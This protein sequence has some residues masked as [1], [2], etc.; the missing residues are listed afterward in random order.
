M[1][2]TSDPSNA[3]ATLIIGCGYLGR[4]LAE[5]LLERGQAV[6]GTCRNPDR[7]EQLSDMGIRPMLVSVTQPVTFA[8]VSPALRHE[9]L[10]VVYLI[11]PGRRGKEPGPREVVLDGMANTLRALRRAP[12]RRAVMASSTAVYGG[13]NNRRVD[14]DSPPETTEPRGQLLIQ[15]E[16]LWL[17]ATHD[18]RVVRFAGL[19]GPGRIIGQSM[20]RERAPLV[21]DPDS[22]LNLLHRD[23][24]VSLLLAMLDADTAGRVELGCDDTPVKRMDYYTHLAERLG[25]DPP[26]VMSEDEAV[27]KLNINPSRLRLAG[28]KTCRNNPTVERTGWRPRY[29][30]FREGLDQALSPS[31]T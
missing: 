24:A 22:K 27:S 6:Y 1:T 30:S 2:Q 23:D 7:A 5:R 31:P 18:T 13:K 25:V 3:P 8:A 26:H 29:P 9:A 4:A 14:A 15:G 12:V 17:D 28:S 20:L 16:Q 10:D 19:Y 11:P 21:G